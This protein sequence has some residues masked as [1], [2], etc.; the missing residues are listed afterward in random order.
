MVSASCAS[1][2][3]AQRFEEIFGFSLPKMVTIKNYIDKP[4]YEI[5]YEISITP[6]EMGYLKSSLKGYSKWHIVGNQQVFASGMTVI[7]GNTLGTQEY[8]FATMLDGRMPV[9]IYDKDTR[10]L[11]AIIADGI[12]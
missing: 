5:V 7:K 6:V 3:P 8:A 1:K 2:N 12:I 11:Y 9:L 10:M 4:G